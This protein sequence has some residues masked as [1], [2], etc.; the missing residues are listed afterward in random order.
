M[1]G[2]IAGPGA[3][4]VNRGKRTRAIAMLKGM[5]ERGVPID[6]VS[7]QG[8]YRLKWPEVGEVELAIRD[9]AALGLKV[10]I[11]EL[12]VDVLPSRGAVGVAHISRSE[13]VDPKLNPYAGG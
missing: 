7:M 9:F 11:S 13:E 8:H 2:G 6:A 4:L 1:F 12:D 10:M 5:M 3:G